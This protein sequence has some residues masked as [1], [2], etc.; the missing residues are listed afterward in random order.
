MSEQPEDE[1]LYSLPPDVM[2]LFEV[3][4]SVKVGDKDFKE[5]WFENTLDEADKRKKHLRGRYC[6][7]DLP[8]EV[9]IKPHAV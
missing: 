2:L 5:S 4:L 6:T 3:Q 1:I 8:A 9:I 7:N